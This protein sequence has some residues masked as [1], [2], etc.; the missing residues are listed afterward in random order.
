MDSSNNDEH[1]QQQDLPE[2][3]TQGQTSETP[4]KL[5]SDPWAMLTDSLG[6]EAVPEPERMEPTAAAPEPTEV[7][8]TAPQRPP[9][10][11]GDLASEFGL[12]VEE[13]TPSE[14]A[15]A[16]Q[17]LSDAAVE[18]AKSHKPDV[19]DDDG[20]ADEVVVEV[21]EVD[22][23]EVESVVVEYEATV[24]DEPVAEAKPPTVDEEPAPAAPVG[25]GGTGLVLPDWFPF[26]GRR[27]PTAEEPK[28]DPAEP[29]A[30]V[31]PTEGV[32]DATAEVEAESDGE[33]D[34]EEKP[35]GRRRRGRRRGR[36]RK[37]EEVDGG[38]DESSLEDGSAVDAPAEDETADESDSA[39]SRSISHKNIPAWQ[40]AI[41]VVVDANIAARGERKRNGRGRGGQRGGRGRRRSGGAKKEA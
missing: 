6:I 23:T 5:E 33:T 9:S 16:A 21:T 26:G 7:E 10:G 28:S 1:D 19:R 14:P 27:K 40:E 15:A 37:K 41:G 22:V 24:E 2:V 30:I 3:E 20:Q 36:G 13:E 4:D 38:A 34:T 18:V 25:F 39:K 17:A 11:W 8:H 31:E 35:R 29:D 32:V 12:E